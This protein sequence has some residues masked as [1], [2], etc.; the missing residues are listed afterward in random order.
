VQIIDLMSSYIR[1]LKREQKLAPRSIVSYESDLR[2]FVRYI[3][4]FKHISE[5]THHSVELYVRKLIEVEKLNDSTVSRKLCAIRSFFRFLENEDFISSSPLTRLPIKIS[6]KRKPLIIMTLEETA[7]FFRTIQNERQQLQKLLSKRRDRGDRERLVMY[8]LMCNVRNNV[9]FSLVY[10]TG[11]K[12]HDL[13]MIPSEY[14]ELRRKSGVI[15]LPHNSPSQGYTISNPEMLKLLKQYQK[16]VHCCGL[17]SHYFFFNRNMGRLSLVMMQ[18]IFK[19]YVKTAGINLCL[20][21]T[22]L[23][24]AY[25]VNLLRN[26]TNIPIIREELG[27]KTF[28]GL[29]IYQDYFNLTAKKRQKRT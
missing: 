11:I 1:K 15:H 10:E 2:L 18:K 23:R 29:L 9:M 7:K 14:V 8:Q 28:E 22:S 17:T 27:Y 16:L 12:L 19:K 4:E 26:N 25:A 24:H 3:G 20:T 5:I 21:P 6:I 13:L